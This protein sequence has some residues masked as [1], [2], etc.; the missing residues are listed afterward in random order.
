MEDIIPVFIIVILFT[1]IPNIRLELNMMLDF[2][3]QQ[4]EDYEGEKRS[5]I[6]LSVKIWLCRNRITILSET[7]RYDLFTVIFLLDS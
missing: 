1:N 6:N 2:I 3:N 5:L 4:G 7:G